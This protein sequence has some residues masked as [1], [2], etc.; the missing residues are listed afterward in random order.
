VPFD[1]KPQ[2]CPNPL[3]VKLKGGSSVSS[4]GFRAGLTGN[5]VLPVAVLGTVEFDVTTIDPASLRLKGIPPLRWSYEDVAT[6]A[7]E[8]E[9]CECTTGGAD[10]FTDLTVKFNKDDVIAAIGPVSDGDEVVLTVT[11][12]LLDGTDIVG[13]DCVLIRAMRSDDADTPSPSA[14]ADGGIVTWNQPNPFNSGTLIDFELGRAGHV[15]IEVY[16][17]LGRRVITLLSD[18]RPA[19]RHSVAWNGRSS[20]GATIASGMYFYRISTAGAA[21]TR[22]MV[23]IK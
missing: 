17:I 16:D 8:D 1:I 14:G 20:T 23:L 19:G 3:N 21:V 6:P 4:S 2:S 13:A 11:G 9:V 5:A 7:I 18:V 10:G 12:L 15:D 22:K